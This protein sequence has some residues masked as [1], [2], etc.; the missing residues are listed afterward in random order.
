MRFRDWIPA[1]VTCLGHGGRAGLKSASKVLAASALCYV[2]TSTQFP[3]KGNWEQWALAEAPPQE[4]TT[5]S[6]A[7][8]NPAS[9]VEKP[10]INQ[11]QL[12]LPSAAALSPWNPSRLW[13]WVWGVRVWFYGREF[14]EAPQG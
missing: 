6:I 1:K 4:E 2:A 10:H 8:A 3:T 11:G 12:G 9:E 7:Q 5:S 13:E 14:L